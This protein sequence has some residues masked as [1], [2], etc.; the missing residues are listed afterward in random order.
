MKKRYFVRPC[1]NLGTLTDSD[2]NLPPRDRTWDVVDRATGNVVAS[3]YH[4]RIL[5]RAE[6]E[7][8]NKEIT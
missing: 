8:R 3:D 2:G 6:A 7:R 1:D 4:S 5:A